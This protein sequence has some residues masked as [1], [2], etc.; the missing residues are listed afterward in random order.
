MTSVNSLN[1]S[2]NLSAAAPQAAPASASADLAKYESQLS[3]SSA[4]TRA[5]ADRL[6]LAVQSLPQIHFDRQLSGA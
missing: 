6:L 4:R 3:D 2:T 1:V 5:S